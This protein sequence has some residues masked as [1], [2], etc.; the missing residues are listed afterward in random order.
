MKRF[1][2]AYQEKK[3]GVSSTTEYSAIQFRSELNVKYKHPVRVPD[4]KEVLA[5]AGLETDVCH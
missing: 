3:L 5:K 4:A 1:K 2:K